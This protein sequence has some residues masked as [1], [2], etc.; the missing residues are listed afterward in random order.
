MNDITD[1][2][3]EQEKTLHADIRN[4][5]SKYDQIT[6]QMLAIVIST[7]CGVSVA[8][9][10]TEKRNHRV[11]A[12]WFLY[13]AYRY[14]TSASYEKICEMF[15]YDGNKPSYSSVRNGILSFSQVVETNKY[16]NDKWSVVRSIIANKGQ[17]TSE[18]NTLTKHVITITIPKELE[19]TITIKTKII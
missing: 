11:F 9:M 3:N 10:M 18:N 17:C 4:I 19:N 6:P 7:L 14:A 13:Y 2:W 8:D 12:R 16:W 15:T 5:M 1:V